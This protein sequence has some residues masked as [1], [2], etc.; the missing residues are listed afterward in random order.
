MLP[1]LRLVVAV[2]LWGGLDGFLASVTL[3]EDESVDG[4][5]CVELRLQRGVGT[6]ANARRV[7]HRTPQGVAFVRPR[8]GAAAALYPQRCMRAIRFEYGGRAA[9]IRAARRI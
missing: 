2:G 5:E 1:L 4:T 7:T 8:R 3:G 9:E 6:V